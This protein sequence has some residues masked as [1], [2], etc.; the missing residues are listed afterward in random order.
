MKRP[1]VR[2]RA[3]LAA[4]AATVIAASAPAAAA[5]APPGPQTPSSGV[6]GV[7]IYNMYFGADLQPLFAPG[8]DPIAATSAIWTEMQDSKIPERAIAVARQIVAE[9]PD[10][11]GL[12]EVS[13]WA[14]SASPTG[15]FVTDYDALSL[16]LADL[17]ALGT[18]YTFVTA[19][20]NF[21]NVTF[22]LP[23]ITPTGLR[24]ATFTDRDVILVRSASLSR[25]RIRLGATQNHTFAAKLQVSVAGQTIDVPRGWSAVDVTVRGRTFRFANTHFE[26][27]GNPPLKD[28][29]RNPQAVELAAAVTASP[30]PFVLVGDLNVRPT[31]CKDYRLGQPEWAGDQNI[32]AYGTLEAAGLTEVWPLV[33]PRNPCGS[34]G[35]TSG[36]S[37]LDNTASTLDH[38]IDDVFVSAG[39]T[40]L[41]AEV[42]GDEEADRTPSG[43]WPSD[44]AST[45]A[46]IRLDNAKRG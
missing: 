31:M 2:W 8:A 39:F 36:Q 16:L 46:R 40:A 11:V 9:Q 5:A 44:H 3:A 13:T 18:P 34:A 28:Q 30:Y 17:A 14:S 29:I 26:A 41:E 7:Q 27:Y 20:T 15:P 21:S 6:G 12:N 22:P 4:V 23:V 32:V 1:S 10:L 35:W 38:R 43:L 42:V 19:N 24:F 37:A 33:Y 25:G 45:W